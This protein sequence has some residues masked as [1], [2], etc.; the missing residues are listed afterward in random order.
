MYSFEPTEEQKML[1]DSTQR[2]ANT[3]LRPA[4]HDADEE[5]SIPKKIIEKDGKLVLPVDAVV[6]SAIREGEKTQVV[7]IEKMPDNL[8][9]LDIGPKTIEL[10]RKYLEKA[11]MVVW[12]GPMGVFEY[13]DFAKGTEEVASIMSGIDAV[14]IV[15]GGDSAAAVD[16]LEVSDKMTHVSTGGG[17][18]LEFLEG[19]KLPA[20]EALEQNYKRLKGKL[21]PEVVVA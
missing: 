7:D 19:R 14:T 1:I 10:F 17:A 11:Q 9:G 8:M 2:F 18:S 6:A 16:K 15:G 13:D 5:G 3:D 21:K 12:N 20:L 4:A